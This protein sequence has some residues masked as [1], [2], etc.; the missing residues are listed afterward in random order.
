M[1]V[2]LFDPVTTTTSGNAFSRS[3]FPNNV[4][5][6]SR[7]DAVGSR[8]AQYYPNPNVA[9]DSCTNL[10]NF[11]SAQK[12]VLTAR[13]TDAKVDWSPTLKDKFFGS[14]SAR[15]RSNV[16][17]AAYGTAGSPSSSPNGDLEPGK[18]TRAFRPQRF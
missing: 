15:D 14:V 10:N 16:V 13:E 17:P 18:S 1:P 3:P 2:Q 5:P 7:I 4:I 12:A 11:F 8:I 9:G 6:T